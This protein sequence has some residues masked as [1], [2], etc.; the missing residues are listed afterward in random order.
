MQQETFT[1]QPGNVWERQPFCSGELLGQGT[2]SH[3][4][5]EA[6]FFIA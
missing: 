5:S 3:L 4:A 2:V 6:F 1:G